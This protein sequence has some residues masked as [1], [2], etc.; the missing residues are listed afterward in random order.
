MKM[1]RYL[2]AA[3]LILGLNGVA[4]AFQFKVLD[5]QAFPVD[6]MP[7]V[8]FIVDFAACPNPPFA[9][10][11]GCWYGTNQSFD[12]ITSLDVIF[13]N[14]GALVGGGVSCDTSAGSLFSSADCALSPDQTEFVLGLS[15]GTGI[16]PGAVFEL[17]ESGVDSSDF[18]EGTGIANAP[19]PGSIWMTLTG[20]TSLGYVLRRRRGWMAS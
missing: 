2:A 13:P 5:P 6:V 19:E 12:T 15:G 17:F 7:G 8:P 10:T 20:V 18:P 4:N 1:F 11:T 3:F 9:S 16:A 14:T